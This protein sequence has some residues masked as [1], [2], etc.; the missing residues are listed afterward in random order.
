MHNKKEEN[1]IKKLVKKNYKNEL[2]E[3]L[4]N[5]Y[6]GENAKSLLLE[7]LYK[8]EA[9]YKDYEK[10]KKD[11]KTKDEYIENYIRIIEKKCKTIKIVKPNSEQS[12][13]L[14]NRT[15]MINKK[16][17]EITC[18]PIA[19]KLLYAISKIDKKEKIVNGKYYL[20]STTLSNLINIGDCINTVEPLREFNGW[21]WTTVAREIE[22][23]EYNLIYQNLLMLAGE[24]LLVDWI[25]NGNTIIDYLEKLKNKISNEYGKKIAK[26]IIN[27]LNEL[28]IILEFK[29][30]PTIKGKIINKK[31]KIES[32]LAKFDNKPIYIKELTLKKNELQKEILKIDTII[33]DQDLLQEEYVKRNKDLPLEE[34]IFSI[35]VL[36][37]LMIEERE[38]LFKQLEEYNSLLKP[39]K[40]LERKE[41]LQKEYDTLKLAD[42]DDE[43]EALKENLLKLQELFLECFEVKIAKAETKQDIID[44]LYRFRYYYLLP[45]S[46]DEN[47]YSLEGLQNKLN[48]I[49]KFLIKKAIYAKTIIEFSKNEE[50]NYEIMKNVFRVRIIA[51]ENLSINISKENNGFFIQ[52]YDDKISEQKIRLDLQELTK[53]NLSV[54]FNKKVKLFE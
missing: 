33:N 52:F 49:G 14:N 38:E 16:R 31:K 6:F 37:N 4:E 10:V 32:A 23:I 50:V 8:I 19:R 21:S 51:L 22:S 15:F 36:A 35:R 54:R 17:S 27:T 1:L 43:E 42:I 5:K 9:A 48:R 39:Q 29:V 2:E 18:L 13:L 41:E 20:L 7:I 53:R 25:K 3:L 34:K 45:Y 44:L 30:N 12:K 11:A 24:K 47:I 28:S 26:D 40:F 46:I